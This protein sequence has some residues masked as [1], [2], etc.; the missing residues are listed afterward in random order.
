MMR[1]DAEVVFEFKKILL[2]TLREMVLAYPVIKPQTEED[3]SIFRRGMNGLQT[4]ISDLERATT[5]RE[6][7]TI[8]NVPSLLEDFDKSSIHEFTQTVTDA[9][10]LNMRQLSDNLED[11]YGADAEDNPR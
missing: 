3:V 9:A 2:S 11:I 7:S 1:E 6:L 10:R 5:V 4:M 8:I